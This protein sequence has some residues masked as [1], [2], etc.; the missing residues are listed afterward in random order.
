MAPAGTPARAAPRD[1]SRAGVERDVVHHADLVAQLGERPLARS[2]SLPSAARRSRSSAGGRRAPSSPTITASGPNPLIADQSTRRAFLPRPTITA[3]IWR[4]LASTSR[5]ATV[6]RSW[7]LARLISLRRAWR[8]ESLTGGRAGPEVVDGRAQADQVVARTPRYVAGIDGGCAG[9]RSSA[10]A[11]AAHLE[12]VQTDACPRGCRADRP[13]PPAGSVRA[14]TTPTRG[15]RIGPWPTS[16]GPSSGS[17]RLDSSATMTGVSGRWRGRL[18]AGQ[19][20][21]PR[22]PG[23][24][25]P[26]VEGQ[27]DEAAL[28][29]P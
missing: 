16:S 25:A 7:A 29:G 22:R 28:S 27:A 13:A 20:A 3:A 26:L 14:R 2:S 24:N 4:A 23:K 10:R 21:A 18:V 5:C 15:R 8:K 11:A 17:T 9:R 1:A 6:P 12:P 19:D